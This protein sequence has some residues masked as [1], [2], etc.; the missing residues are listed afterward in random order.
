MQLFPACF[1]PS[2]VYGICVDV[3]ACEGGCE[4]VCVVR[5]RGC[6]CV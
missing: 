6:A 5:V 3:H 2:I 4:S 1:D